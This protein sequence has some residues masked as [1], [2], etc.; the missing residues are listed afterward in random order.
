MDE[1]NQKGLCIFFIKKDILVCQL[2][3][4]KYFENVYVCCAVQS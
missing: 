3:I 2:S 1:V 4:N